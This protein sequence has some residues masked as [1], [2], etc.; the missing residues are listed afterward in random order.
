MG[1]SAGTPV[2]VAEYVCDQAPLSVSWV[3][4]LGCLLWQEFLMWRRKPEAISLLRS[5]KFWSIPA[6]TARRGAV[7]CTSPSAESCRQVNSNPWLCDYADVATVAV[8]SCSLRSSFQAGYFKR[9][10]TFSL[11]SH[12]IVRKHNAEWHSKSIIWSLWCM[13]NLLVTIHR[14][15]L[16]IQSRR[17]RPK[18]FCQLWTDR[19]RKY[20]TAKNEH[21]CILV[22]PCMVLQPYKDRWFLSHFSYYSKTHLM[23]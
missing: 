8:V 3:C 19:W 2:L 4:P 7:R 1:T 22:V 10:P 12:P 23:E 15:N 13:G 18:L 6:L 5:K 11:Q 17:V 16:K 21:I 14:R 9:N 20:V